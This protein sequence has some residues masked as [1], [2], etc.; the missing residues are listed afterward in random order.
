[1]APEQSTHVSR[2]RAVCVNLHKNMT[3]FC[4][5]LRRPYCLVWCS[6][7]TQRR[8]W[9]VDSWWLVG[10]QSRVPSGRQSS[11]FQVDRQLRSTSKSVIESKLHAC[12]YLLFISKYLYVAN[13]MEILIYFHKN[14]LL[15]RNF[16]TIN[17]ILKEEFT[18]LF[19]SILFI[20]TF[21][22]RFWYCTH[23]LNHQNINKCSFKSYN[24]NNAST[25]Y[26]KHTS[27]W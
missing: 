10:G 26:T 13:N 25:V 6:H 7:T 18:F 22:I 19:Q 1:M 14:L 2:C 12:L 27:P 23:R 20:C 4:M 5:W 3:L 8:I 11:L 9:P 24:H 21:T 17:T 15:I 16:L